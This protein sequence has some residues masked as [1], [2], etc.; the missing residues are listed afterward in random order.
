MMAET[1]CRL[2]ELSS[3]AALRSG[4]V[5]TQGS[6]GPG[7]NLE[8]AK[9][10]PAVRKDERPSIGWRGLAVRRPQPDLFFEWLE[11]GEHLLGFRE[12]FQ[13]HAVAD[14]EHFIPEREHVGILVRSVDRGL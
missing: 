8:T 4:D 5:L 11:A 10:V 12:C 13:R 1:L 9:G 6:E 3:F 2:G 7:R 14:R